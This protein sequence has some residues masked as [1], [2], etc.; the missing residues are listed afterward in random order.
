LEYQLKLE[1]LHE[2]EAQQYDEAIAAFD[3]MLSKLNDTSSTVQNR[4]KLHVAHG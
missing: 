2:L 1:V 3:I 4:S